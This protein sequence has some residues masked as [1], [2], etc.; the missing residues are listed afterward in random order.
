MMKISEEDKRNMIRTVSA[1]HPAM[2]LGVD[3]C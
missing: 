2:H 3:R 1:R